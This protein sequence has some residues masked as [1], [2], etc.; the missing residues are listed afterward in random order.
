M[1]TGSK[2]P[3][4]PHSRAVYH[5][6]HSAEETEAWTGTWRKGVLGGTWRMLPPPARCS[7]T[8]PAPKCFSERVRGCQS[9][10]TRRLARHRAL[11]RAINHPR[12]SRAPTGSICILL[13]PARSPHPPSWPANHQPSW[14][15]ADK[16]PHFSL[17]PLCSSATKVPAV[18]CFPRPCQW[19]TRPGTV[20]RAA[21]GA[22]GT[23]PSATTPTLSPST[24]GQPLLGPESKKALAL[25]S[26]NAAWLVLAL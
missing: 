4:T 14:E 1:S 24:S 12:P 19:L 15:G 2:C 5:P 20:G 3:S 25:T 10:C 17:W 9:R 13:T 23:V 21:P 7:R 18:G 6:H 26:V 22:C 11:R 16:M 8:K